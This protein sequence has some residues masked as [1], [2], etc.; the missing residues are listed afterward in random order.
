MVFLATVGIEKGNF[1]A[2]PRVFVSSTY[3]DLKHLRSS[4]DI[5]VEGLG[6]EPILSE[7]GDI[8]YSPD[9]PLDES[10]YREVESADIFVLLVGGR[11]GSEASGKEKRPS[12]QFFERYESIT[13]KE[14]ESALRKDTP[15]YILIESN[16]Y[17]EYHTFLKNK[18]NKEIAYAHVDSANIFH[19]IEEILS[20]PR[21]NPTHTFERFSDIEEWLR[22]QW[23]GLF[24]ELLNRKSQ[25]QQLANLSLQVSDLKEI[26]N[27]LKRYL[28]AVMAGITPAA[29]TELIETEQR[30]LQEVERR[31][32][33]YGNPWVRHL[34][35]FYKLPTD[36]VI[37][38]IQHATSFP[39]FVERLGKAKANASV[40][41]GILETLE[42]IK[43]AR[44]DFNQ[45]RSI[46]NL[47]PLPD[48]STIVTEELPA[49]NAAKVKRKKAAAGRTQASR[50]K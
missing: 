15:T 38:A 12:R 24:R 35:R 14:Y 41:S 10:C 16:V 50:K 25:Q 29:S 36:V 11:Y 49:D 43:E 9:L 45:A 23:A 4:L 37:E 40:K 46:L 47:E 19:L 32:R 34:E 20:K 21:N 3:Y 1:M 30:R 26:N 6:F 8:A 39:D 44:R 17:A 48:P 18:E 7:K 27:T 28:E 22:D 33:L 5:F 2:K 42:S 13:K 31:E